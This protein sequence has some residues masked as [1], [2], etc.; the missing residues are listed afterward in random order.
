MENQPPRSTEEVDL[1][2]IFVKI[3]EFLKSLITGVIKFIAFLRNTPLQNKGTF[4][5]LIVVG[6]IFGWAYSSFIKKKFY[7]SSMILSSDYLNKR[8]V[9]N[10][11][12]KL[13]LLAAET[14]TKGLAAALQIPDS[15]A[16]K[17]VKFEAR[18]F[19]AEKELVEMEVLKEQLKNAQLNGKNQNVIDQVIKKIEI[20]NQH[21]FEF[22][23]RTFNPTAI[24]PLQDALVN[25]FKNND[26]IKKRIKINRE[27]LVL[28]KGKLERESQKLDSLKRVIY[29]N[30]QSM[31][32]RK[33]GS[34]NV[35]LSD[36]SV[37]N[38]IEIYAQ[39][40]ELYDQLQ[41]VEKGIFLQ[42]DFEVI[43][44]F[45]EFSE[46]ASASSSKIVATSAL[47]AFI[48]SYILVSL[49]KFDTYLSHLE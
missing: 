33:Q 8:I 45:T 34:N 7:D 46:P 16:Q 19:V 40:L 18:P 23:V 44:G 14:T 11:I 41:R 15:L 4:G 24:R 39:D 3:G 48:L 22:T 20:E 36:K 28:R 6:G 12:G 37:T 9:D 49:R 5:L 10:S 35:I 25:Y 31:S 29:S 42:P 43:D 47:I 21:A 26:Y 38:P 30:Y 32:E 13:N 27:N 1:G 17:I 2:Q